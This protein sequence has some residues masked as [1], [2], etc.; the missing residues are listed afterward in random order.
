M[1]GEDSKA[2]FP[3]DESSWTEEFQ[4]NAP[5]M[6]EEDSPGFGLII[7]GT[8]V[9]MAA[10]ALNKPSRSEDEEIQRISILILSLVIH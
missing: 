7:V 1:L 3:I 9:A 4:T 8:S 6:Q 2:E 10:I 5:I